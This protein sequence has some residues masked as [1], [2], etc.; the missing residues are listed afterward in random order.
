LL[1]GNINSVTNTI[2]TIPIYNIIAYIVLP[3]FSI[4]I[5]YFIQRID[6]YEI[7][8]R[9]SHIYIFML[10]EF[11]IIIISYTKVFSINLDI[12]ETRIL[13][14]F[15]HLYYYVP[16]IYFLAKPKANL[17]YSFGSESSFIAKRLRFLATIIYNIGENIIALLVSI[18]L[19]LYN[20]FP[21]LNTLK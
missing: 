16:V 5:L 17:N 10:I 7:Y 13:Q 19:I 2:N 4:I 9:F 3:L 6:L 14:F 15:V 18:I 11:C 1:S 20:I 8:N 12:L 21:L